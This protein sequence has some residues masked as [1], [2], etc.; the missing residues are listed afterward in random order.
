MNWSYFGHV[1]GCVWVACKWYGSSCPEVT[2]THATHTYPHFHVCVDKPSTL[3]LTLVQ[4]L[5]E[6]WRSACT[7]Q[8]HTNPHL[9]PQTLKPKGMHPE[10]LQQLVKW[11]NGVL[12]PF[13]FCR[14]LAVVEND[15]HAA[16][17]AAL[18]HTCSHPDPTVDPHRVQS[19]CACMPTAQASSAGFY[20]TRNP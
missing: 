2:N 12:R 10:P 8:R 3:A 9:K 4:T 14:L 20:Q 19:L 7:A 17:P 18:S 11:P 5:T 1:V 13:L 16:L 6:S 15:M